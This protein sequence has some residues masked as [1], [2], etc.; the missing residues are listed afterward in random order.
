MA[1]LEIYAR[2]GGPD[3]LR[4]HRLVQQR[5][6]Q[7]RRGRKVLHHARS[8]KR[9]RYG[10]SRRVREHSDH[11]HLDE[12][13]RDDEAHAR[14]SL[15]P[16]LPVASPALPTRRTRLALA[17]AQQRPEGVE[18]PQ[19]VARP[20]LDAGAEDFELKRQDVLEDVRPRGGGRSGKAGEQVGDLGRGLV[21]EP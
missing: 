10:D 2:D 5:L 7:L 15:H 19:W 12:L 18:V 11:L 1:C 21:E 4:L 14:A 13:R 9:T 8:I 6:Q 3:L 17:L 20:V 16:H